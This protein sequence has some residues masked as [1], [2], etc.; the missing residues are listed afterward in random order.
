M[1]LPPGRSCSARAAV[2]ACNQP[3][4]GRR[5]ALAKEKGQLVAAPIRRLCVYCGSSIGADARYRAAAAALGA[6]LAAARFELV[7]AGGRHP[8]V[9]AGPPPGPGAPSTPTP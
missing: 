1:S 5:G 6:G 3:R 9:G 2:A 7:Y 8:V 4:F